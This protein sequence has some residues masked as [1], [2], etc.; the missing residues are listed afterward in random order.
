MW[1]IKPYSAKLLRKPAADPPIAEQGTHE[2][3]IALGEIYAWMYR[4]QIQLR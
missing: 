3:L 2:E 1:Q 4:K